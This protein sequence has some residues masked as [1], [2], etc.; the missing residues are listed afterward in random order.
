MLNRYRKIQ[1]IELGNSKR[2][3]KITKYKK[4]C[5]SSLMQ[6]TGGGG[7]RRRCEEDD[8]GSKERGKS[9]L[10]GLPS[11]IQVYVMIPSLSDV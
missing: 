7:K 11:N 9:G 2:A 6:I 8:G 3:K 1:I 4:M 10:C 5:L